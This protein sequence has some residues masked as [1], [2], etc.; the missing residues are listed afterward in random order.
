MDFANVVVENAGL[1]LKCNGAKYG[2]LFQLSLGRIKNAASV[3]EAIKQLWRNFDEASK[4]YHTGDAGKLKYS[5]PFIAK[6]RAAFAAAAVKPAK[7]A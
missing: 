5:Q 4:D 7:S 1:G 6:I 2:E 3:D